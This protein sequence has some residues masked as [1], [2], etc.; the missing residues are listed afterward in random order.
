M[1]WGTCLLLFVVCIG[2]DPQEGTSKQRCAQIEEDH[3]VGT[4]SHQQHQCWVCPCL[5]MFMETRDHSKEHLTDLSLILLLIVKITPS[6]I[7]CISLSIYLDSSQV[8]S[9]KVN[10]KSSELLNFLKLFFT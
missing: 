8:K 6:A 5:S 1:C 10:Y 3:K 9:F 4:V 2:G 7:I